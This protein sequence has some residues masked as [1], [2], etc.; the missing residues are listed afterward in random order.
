MDIY[1]FLNSSDVAAHCREINK[2]WSSFDIAVIIGRSHKTM[3]EKHTAWRELMADY[4]DMPT[5]K[6][7]HF[8]S[9]PSLFKKIAEVIFYE[10]QLLDLLKKQEHS[11]VYRHSDSDSIFSSYESVLADMRDIWEKDEKPTIAIEKQYIDDKGDIVCRMD[12]DGNIFS[13]S[14]NVDESVLAK[15]FPNWDIETCYDCAHFL[16]HGFFV[17][18]P[19]PFKRGDILTF[20]GSA[21]AHKK[22][23]ILVLESTTSCYENAHKRFINHESGDGSDLVGWGYFVGEDGLL[24]EDHVHEEDELGYC[25]SKL[26]GDARLLQYVSW[27]LRNEI[28]LSA[29]LTVQCRIVVQHQLDNDLSISGLWL[30][31]DKH[32]IADGQAEHEIYGRDALNNVDAENGGLAD[33]EG[34]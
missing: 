3:T 2:V 19:L 18:I 7:M 28:C 1:S 14:L 29:L 5:P 32:I 27:Y 17:D 34:D 16:E 21:Y 23:R 8:K 30:F 33:R 9:F 22:K 24:H 15:M 26:E 11:A 12:F 10:E 20:S 31:P 4:P 25:R 6:N 13:V